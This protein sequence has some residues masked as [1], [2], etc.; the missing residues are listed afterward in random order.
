MGGKILRVPSIP[1]TLLPFIF[2]FFIFFIIFAT[3]DKLQ[4][5][6]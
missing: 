3:Q 4:L 6:G 1:L 2:N 5:I